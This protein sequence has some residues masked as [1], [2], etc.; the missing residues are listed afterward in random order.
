MPYKIAP[1]YIFVIFGSQCPIS[2]TSGIGN[3]HISCPTKQ[4]FDL[5][6]DCLDIFAFGDITADGNYG[7]AWMTEILQL[8]R[9]LF[10][11]FESSACYNHT[12]C[13]C[14]DPNSSGGLPS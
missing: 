11:N 6:K 8:D 5:F 14:F 9:C 10:E 3:H 4:S 12:S 2:R 13:S 7:C 1:P